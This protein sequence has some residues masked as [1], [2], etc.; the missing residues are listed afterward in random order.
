[1]DMS[2]FVMM[3]TSFGIA[4]NATRPEKAIVAV[5]TVHLIIGGNSSRRN[6]KSCPVLETT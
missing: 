5:W 3:I 2:T 1:M 4:N 6:I